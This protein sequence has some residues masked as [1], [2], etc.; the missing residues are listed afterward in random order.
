MTRA[1]NVPA[2]ITERPAG[3]P[4][5]AAEIAERAADYAA[6][7][8]S[9]N[10]RL[11][12]ASDWA[13]FQAWCDLQGAVALPADPAVVL[14]FLV[15]TAGQVK[16]S[17]QR[18]RLS[19]IK[20]MQR[21]AGFHL[22]TTSATFRDVWRGIRRAHGQPPVKKAALMTP[23]LRRALGTLPDSLT[24]VRDRALLLLGF[25]GALRRTELAGVEASVR[26]GADWLEETGD[27]LVVHLAKSKGDQ[28]GDGQVV[29]VPF[30]SH[31]ETCPVRAVRAWLQ[32]G[33]ITGGPVFR[34]INRHG[35]VGDEALC[36]HSVAF[37]IKRVIVAGA[38][39]GGATEEEAAVTARRFAGHSLRSGLATSAA[40]NDTPGHLIQRQ[41]RH[42]KFDTTVGY[43][44]EAELLK[45]NAAAMVGL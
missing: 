43:I 16:V 31:P 26:P 34:Q 14:A 1:S 3:L 24:G 12:Y 36:D 19:A 4:A 33:Q 15:D 25:A 11:A 41:L 9:D 38:R 5:S 27:G 20:E 37:V 44:Q 2:I 28:E 40:A 17:T 35:R 45:K 18:R 23:L 32:A 22:D 21:Q 10:T 6:Q 30:G 42:K 8:Q 7:A 39:A 13:V 29:G